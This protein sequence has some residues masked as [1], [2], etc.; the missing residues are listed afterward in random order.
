MD[1]LLASVQVMKCTCTSNTSQKFCVIKVHC[2]SVLT[3]ITILVI[4]ATGR[5]RNREMLLANE[6]QNFKLLAQKVHV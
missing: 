1:G 2:Y 6:K 3:I 4:I 5:D